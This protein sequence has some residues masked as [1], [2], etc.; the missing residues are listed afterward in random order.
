MSVLEKEIEGIQRWIATGKQNAC[1]NGGYHRWVSKTK[2]KLGERRYCTRCKTPMPS[3]VTRFGKKLRAELEARLARLLAIQ[4][5][6]E[7][8]GRG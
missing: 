5:Q 2:I 6:E 1:T 8:H 3:Q 4:K 7:E